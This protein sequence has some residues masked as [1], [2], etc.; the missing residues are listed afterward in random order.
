MKTPLLLLLF[1]LMIP[2]PSSS[3]QLQSLSKGSSLFSDKPDDVLVSPNGVFF[4]GFYGVGDNAYCFA[5]WFAKSFGSTVVWI[6]NRDHPVNGIGSSL[7]LVSD[8]NLLLTD[9]G[10][11]NIWVTSTIS[12]SSVHLC[13]MD[14]GNLVLETSKNFILWQSFD[15]PTDTLLPQQPLTRN[16]K[17]VSSRTRGNYS[18]GSYS[19]YFDNDNVLRILFDGPMTSSIYWPD[20]SISIWSAGRTTYNNTRIGV[21]DLSG[22]FLSSD[23]FK[24]LAADLGEGPK[25][26]LTIDF[27]GNLR[28]YS[29]NEKLDWDVSWQAINAPCK[30][31]GI[32]GPNSI[33]VYEPDRRC[34]CL[35][36]FVVK[37]RT[38]WSYGCE[39]RSNFSFEGAKSKFVNLHNV[40][41][42]GYDLNFFHNVTWENCKKNC[43]QQFTCKAF[44]YR[45]DNGMYDCYL[46]SFLLNGYRAPDFQG[47]MYLRVPEDS[48]ES[49]ND[50]S[51]VLS[52]SSEAHEELPRMYKEKHDTRYL[53]YLFW[54]VSI[55]GGVEMI[56]I[57]LGWWFLFKT[58]GNSSIFDQG[59]LSAASG[60]R[61][62]TY[63]ELKKE[64][65]CFT[66]E[67][68]RGGGGVVYKG[69]LSDNRVAA[70]KR[71]HE[72]NQEEGEFFAEVSIIGRINHMNL[73]E[74]WGFCAE[75]K[76]RLLVYEYMEHGSLA[77][78]LL[79]NVFDWEKRLKTALGTAK[80]L[81]YLH[82]ECLEWVLHCDVKPQNI[83]LDENFNPKVADFG[84]SKLLD[85]GNLNN[86]DFSAIRGT[87]GYM[88]PEWVYSLPITSKVDVYSYGIVVLELVTGKSPTGSYVV[89]S[90]GET[91]PR[92]LV[93]WVREKIEANSTSM[94]SG[95][96]EIMDS[97]IVEQCDLV[98][99]E[100]LMRIALQCV[101]EERDARPTMKQV[102]EM[103]QRLGR[104]H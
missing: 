24:F 19:L 80:G 36:G 84:L 5:I 77:K 67:I 18:S 3:I 40:D 52:C 39:S 28:L 33:C 46:K 69:V 86:T 60:F 62:F 41:F 54:F 71:L 42:Y 51:H 23:S 87:R 57:I 37:D 14:T 45:M 4:A 47:S 78:N 49:L 74:M 97:R 65:R 102:V 29:L 103:L 101:E 7:S 27:D 93:T 11:I 48:S 6:A 61:K 31:H 91:E 90:L 92:H 98:K 64:T 75:G 2:S 73:I 89:E 55:I 21:L 72:A 50:T 16:T 94:G 70:I 68:G 26:R 12:T 13:L 43:L 79:S 82:E 25:R 20:P 10:Q 88:A 8:G 59:Y 58:Q 81:A 17:L 83:L 99:A 44:M 34:S 30:T 35:P 63:A 66:E 22:H 95:F 56:C 85:R 53:R 104:D 100:I 15:S 9:A 38:D 76:H 1:T 96:E 32:C